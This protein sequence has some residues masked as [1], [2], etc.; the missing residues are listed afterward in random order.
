MSKF[1][2]ILAL[3]EQLYTALATGN[4]PSS[5]T[6]RHLISVALRSS[7]ETI[8][9]EDREKLGYILRLWGSYLVSQGEDFPDIDIDHP[10]RRPEVISTY[11]LSTWKQDFIDRYEH[12][13]PDLPESGKHELR[14]PRGRARKE[15]VLVV[16]QLS[17]GN[18]YVN[19]IIPYANPLYWDNRPTLNIPEDQIVPIDDLV[20]FHPSMTPLKKYYDEGKLAIIHGIG[21]HNAPRSHFRSMDIWHTCEPDTVGTEG[22]L[23]RA[24][25]EIDPRKENMLKGVSFGPSFFRAMSL[26]GVPVACVSGALENYGMLPGIQNEQRTIVLE[27]FMNTYA[28][29]VGLG[30]VMDYLGTTGLDSLAGADILKTAPQQYS[31]TVTYP[32]SMVAQK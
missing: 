27:R 21:C 29:T 5:E 15:P 4:Q 26:Q 28:P 18:D 30:T 12:S 32:A 23:G 20:G 22:W 19:T 14:E 25:R 7:Q 1:D 31:S 8:Y 17:G 10:K 11:R 6:I 16:L 13:N 24:L 2:E 9:L 3:H